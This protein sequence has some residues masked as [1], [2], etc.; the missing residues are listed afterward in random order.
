MTDKRK[1]QTARKLQQTDIAQEEMGMNRLQADDQ[2]NVRNQRKAVPDV[3]REPD[4]DVIESFEK[5]DKD[6]RAREELGKGNR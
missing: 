5:L 4:K 2:E 1:V 3:K 6:R